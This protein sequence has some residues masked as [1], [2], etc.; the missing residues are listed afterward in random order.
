MVSLFIF[1]TW[2]VIRLSFGSPDRLLFLPLLIHINMQAATI[3]SIISAT[4]LTYSLLKEER[5]FKIFNSVMAIGSI[6]FLIGTKPYKG[7]GFITIL[8]G[9]VIT[10]IYLL[11][12]RDLEKKQRNL[13]VFSG[14]MFL[15]ATIPRIMHWPGGGL[16]ALFCGIPVLLSIIWLLSNAKK[17]PKFLSPLI[18]T[19]PLCM[20]QFTWMIQAIIR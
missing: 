12:R 2:K 10:A 9:I 6:L 20:I 5:N 3:L 14:I 15:A 13:A 11:Y 16:I 8:I 18:V 7:I 1:W 19:V 17:D 4:G